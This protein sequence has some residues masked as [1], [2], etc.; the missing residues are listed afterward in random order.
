ML[1]TGCGG[2]MPMMYQLNILCR[3]MLEGEEPFPALPEGKC[4]IYTGGNYIFP[5]NFL[6]YKVF[7]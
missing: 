7:V 6:L 2:G 5:L 1:V 3:N 4:F